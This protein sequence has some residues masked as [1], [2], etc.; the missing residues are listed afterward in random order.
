MAR[1][2][3]AWPPSQ[4]VSWAVVIPA[5][6][7]TTSGLSCEAAKASPW[8]TA[9]ITCGL[10][11]NSHSPAPCTA[12]VAASNTCTPNWPAS[13]WR[14]SAT[15]SATRIVAGSVPRAISPPIRLRAMLPPPMKAIVDSGAGTGDGGL[16]AVMAICS[17]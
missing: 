14:S 9:R 16:G 1:T 3:A 4:R 11:A 8:H 6:I 2:T 13:A 17:G 10:T 15:G 5:A 12:S 7:D